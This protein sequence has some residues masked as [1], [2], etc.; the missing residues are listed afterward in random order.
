MLARTDR[1][2]DEGDPTVATRALTWSRPP[3]SVRFSPTRDTSFEL[4]YRLVVPRRG[5]VRLG[6]ADSVAVRTTGAVSLGRHGARD[7]MPAPRVS[8]PRPGSTVSGSKLKVTGVVTAGANGLPV[9]VDVSAPGVVG[10]QAKLKPNK[11]GTRAKYVIT[12]T[13]VGQGSHRITVMATD[14]VGLHRSTKLTV[15][16]K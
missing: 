10:G 6:F 7:M 5:S 12:L 15:K 16:T 14:A 9:S 2:G 11:A 4:D 3:S 1:F 8:S 13:H